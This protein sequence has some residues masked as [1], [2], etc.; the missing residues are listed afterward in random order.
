[1]PCSHLRYMGYFRNFLR[2]SWLITLIPSSLY[3]F[4]LMVVTRLLSLIRSDTLGQLLDHNNL[5]L[6]ARS[7]TIATASPFFQSM[8]HPPKSQVVLIAVVSSSAIS[9]KQL[10]QKLVLLLIVYHKIITLSTVF[11]SL[12]L[13]NYLIH[14][15]K[16]ITTQTKTE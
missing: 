5:I 9:Y 7:S 15:N 8:G 1:M 6:V 11:H 12:L 10:I 14:Y 3:H 2:I 16:Y 13:I 4:W